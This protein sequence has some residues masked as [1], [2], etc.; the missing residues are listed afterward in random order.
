MEASYSNDSA[1]LLSD[2][3]EMKDLTVVLARMLK[4]YKI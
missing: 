2:W 1:E 3:H 4:I